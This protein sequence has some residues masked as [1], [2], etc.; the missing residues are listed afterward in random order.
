MRKRHLFA[1]LLAGLL[2]SGCAAPAQTPAAESL[3]EEVPAIVETTLPETPPAQ[4]QTEAV[5]SASPVYEAPVPAEEPETQQ[6]AEVP[7]K[8]TCTLSIRCATILD[9]LEDL[10]P[11]KEDLVPADGWLLPAT[12]VPMEEGDSVFD[13]LERTCRDTKLHM[14]FEDTPL[15]N[16][17]YIE[18]IGNLYEFDCGPLSGWQYRVNGW[19]PNFGCSQYQVQSGDV[20]EWVY[21][22]D[23][24]ADVG[25]EVP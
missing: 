1:A 6:E 14:E 25:G 12:E 15:Y 21:T 3:I 24:G 22:C 10:T 16:S 11:G 5:T 13:V 17:A 2:L 19:F 4:E 23:L 9:H 20:I 8:R 18:G 7:A